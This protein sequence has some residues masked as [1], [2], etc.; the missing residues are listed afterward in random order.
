MTSKGTKGGQGKWRISWTRP[1]CT[2]VIS[3]HVPLARTQA[4]AFLSVGILKSMV[5]L[6][7]R[8][9]EDYLLDT[10]MGLCYT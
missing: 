8:R 3:T 1:Q 4:L 2:Y 9:E 10:Y 5:E 7:I 6:S